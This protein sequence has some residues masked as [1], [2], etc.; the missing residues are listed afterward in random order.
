MTEA[1]AQVES[2]FSCITFILRRLT[3]EE[4]E[5]LTFQYFV[6]QFKIYNDII[7]S[8]RM[9]IDNSESLKKEFHLSI[10]Q[11]L[12]SNFL[13]E[14]IKKETKLYLKEVEYNTSNELKEDP[15]IEVTQPIQDLNPDFRQEDIIE[16]AKGCDKTMNANVEEGIIDIN[17]TSDESKEDP[18]IEVTPP[19]QDLNPIRI[20][21]IGQSNHKMKRPLK[22]VKKEIFKC[23]VC[24]LIYEAQEEMRQ[25]DDELHVQNGKFIC[26]EQCDFKSLRKKDFVLHYLSIHKSKKLYKCSECPEE[27]F[28]DISSYRD[29]L[30]KDHE[31]DV[32]ANTCPFCF[33]SFEKS[34]L[35]H[36]VER[37]HNKVK[38]QCN[39]CQKVFHSKNG[40]KIHTD[41]H[42][43]ASVV[44]CNFCG[45]SF[46]NK[47]L[48]ESHVEAHH[49]N[50]KYDCKICAKSY[51][52]KARLSSHIR[53]THND[54][55]ISCDQCEY[56]T[57]NITR[58]KAHK[59]IHKDER[60]YSCDLCDFK[61]KRK[62]EVKKHRSSHFD[63][64]NFL[65]DV[66]EK[67]FRLQANLITHQK[68]HTNSYAAF[69]DQCGRGFIQKYNLLLHNR[70]HHP[71][72]LLLSK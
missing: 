7:N 14:I 10:L 5:S 16:S 46:N 63:E 50:S 59:V 22:H 19:I 42:S 67:S 41:M 1:I 3:N 45:K 57:L 15:I 6:D 35:Y 69:C 40:L 24:D 54:K 66:C 23:V 13:E 26:S 11:F 44:A 56:K 32:D 52:S 30:R 21:E 9:Q 39:I 31:L 8:H 51:S 70:N 47:Y 53:N 48:L 17:N 20:E 37:E 65:C 61:F 49:M 71:E 18:I 62:D 33:K 4:A 12:D 43:G 58:L 64:K 27:F 2:L 55:R 38:L 60:L 68:I 29:H 36:H 25:H 28:M 72:K 34:K